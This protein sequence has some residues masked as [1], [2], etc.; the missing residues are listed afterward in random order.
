M[1]HP[2]PT[3]DVAAEIA[4][5]LLGAPL[6]SVARFP[7]GTSHFVFDIETVGGERAVLRLSRRDAIE[8]ARGSVTWS[9]AL[10]PIGVP[11]PEI[12]HADLALTRYPFPVVLLERL[13]G[14][15]LENVYRR[16]PHDA[17]RALAERLAAIQ[18]GVSR[19]PAGQGF[20]YA[21]SRDGPFT[22]RTWRGVV[23]AS[24]ARSRL[25]IRAAGIFD[26]SLIDRVETVAARFG[27]LDRVGATPFLHDITTRNVIVHQGRLSGIVDVDD[28][29]FGDPLLLVALI[30]MALM[31]HQLDQAYFDMWIAV[32]R[33]DA[34][35]RVAIDF[36]TL[37]CCV[38]FM[39]EIGQRFNRSDV[40]VDPAYVARLRTIYDGLLARVEAAVG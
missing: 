40:A 14:D 18:H 39:G 28:L 6:R 34:E 4:A 24:L 15:D 2:D 3:A 33:P 27:Y 5:A 9:R 38:D 1:H 22:A 17:L 35:Q 12:L 8:A 26:E 31:A 11:L 37:Q 10:R 23:A 20:G 30:C 29:C 32:L 19:L 16:L 13:P 36:Y 25:R 21:P 7:T